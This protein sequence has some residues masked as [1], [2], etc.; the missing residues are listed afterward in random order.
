MNDLSH[1]YVCKGFLFGSC[2]FNPKCCRKDIYTRGRR[3]QNSYISPEILTRIKH[4]NGHSDTVCG[5]HFDFVPVYKLM[6]A[7]SAFVAHQNRLRSLLG[8]L[9]G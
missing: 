1:V 6:C 3:I 7:A 9:T 2:L 5:Q 4:G 8:L